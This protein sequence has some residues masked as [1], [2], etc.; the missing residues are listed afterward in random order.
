[1]IEFFYY[2]PQ[3]KFAKVM[4]LHLPVSHSVHQGDLHPRGCL[5]PGA[6]GQNPPSDTVGCGQ[7]EGGTHPTGMHSSLFSFYLFK[8]YICCRFRNVEKGPFA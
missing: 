5:H 3:T 7:R 1:M 4:F 6:V 2:H 8:N